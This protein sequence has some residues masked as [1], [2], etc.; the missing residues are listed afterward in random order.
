MEEKKNTLVKLL[1]A[2]KWL[3]SYIYT[4]IVCKE[5][6]LGSFLAVQWL[7]LGASTVR[8]I[9]FMPSWR[10]KILHIMWHGQ[11]I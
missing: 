10:T 11:N 1:A 3:T 7:R 8:G 5:H 2:Y 9:D 6:N 4:S